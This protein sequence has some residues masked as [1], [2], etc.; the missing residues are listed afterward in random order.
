MIVILRNH[1]VTKFEVHM[2][3]RKKQKE[4]DSHI[5]YNQN[6]HPY[7]YRRRAL[8]P[9]LARSV[10]LGASRLAQVRADR[11]VMAAPSLTTQRFPF[12]RPPLPRSNRKEIIVPCKIHII[13]IVQW[14]ILGYFRKKYQSR[15]K[16]HYWSSVSNKIQCSI[17]LKCM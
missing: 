2:Q 10:G 15:K 4:C 9:A 3:P 14:A 16:L 13:T 5:Q 8:Q 17:I 7:L 12:L 1:V 6:S 11:L